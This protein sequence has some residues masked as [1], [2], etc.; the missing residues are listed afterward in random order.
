MH[1]YSLKQAMELGLRLLTT[2]CYLKLIFQSMYFLNRLHCSGTNIS[3]RFETLAAKSKNGGQD[4]PGFTLICAT[5]RGDAW[6]EQ[7]KLSGSI[8]PRVLL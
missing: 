3:Y 8:I 2:V 7:E 4:I 6:V 1:L 5:I